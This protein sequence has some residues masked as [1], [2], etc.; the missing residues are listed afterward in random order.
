LKRYRRNGD[1]VWLDKYNENSERVLEKHYCRCLDRPDTRPAFGTM[2]KL[3]VDR[4]TGNK[5]TLAD[6]ARARQEAINIW[7]VS[8]MPYIPHGHKIK[9][10]SSQPPSWLQRKA[11]RLQKAMTCQ[12]NNALESMDVR[13]L[14][15][16]RRLQAIQINPFK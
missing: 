13:H 16:W 15:Y 9:C 7:Y 4:L 1:Q 10:Q 8:T 11:Q 3:K 12:Y 2:P 14:A 5:T 6:H